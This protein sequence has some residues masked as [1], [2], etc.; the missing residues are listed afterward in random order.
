MGWMRPYMLCELNKHPRDSEI[1]FEAEGHIYTVQG[2]TGFTSVTTWLHR[3]FEEFDADAILTRMFSGSGPGPRSKYHGM[4]R[5][6]VEKQWE[7]GREAAS[8]AGTQLHDE[9]E[10]FYNGLGEGVKGARASEDYRLFE[11]FE[12]DHGHLVPYRTEWMIWDTDLRLAGS[13]DM[14]F[15]TGNEQGGR[16]EVDIYDWKRCK[17]IRRTSPWSK[18]GTTACTEHLPDTNYWHYSLQLNIYAALLQKHYDVHVR[19]LWLVC[20][21]PRQDRYLRMRVPWLRDEAV[22]LFESR[23]MEVS[24]SEPR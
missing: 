8:A 13:I 10:R 14:V 19:E 21:H 2:D 3:N 20:L 7:D 23:S 11:G 4:T 5:E 16:K 9:I 17:E 1:G 6:A 24:G 18:F 22:A 12:A 15:G